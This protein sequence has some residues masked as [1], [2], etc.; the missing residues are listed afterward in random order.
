MRILIGNSVG[1]LLMTL[2]AGTVF[3]SAGLPRQECR[4]E[5]NAVY[6]VYL[7]TYTQGVSRGIYTCEMDTARGTLSAPKLVAEARN[8]S[9]LALHPTL[10]RL[11]AVSELWQTDGPDRGAVSA[12]A[13]DDASGGLRELNQEAVGGA[14]PCH[15]AASPSGRFLVTANYGSGSV[16]VLPLDDEGRLRPRSCVVQHEGSGPNQSRQEGPHAHQ[17]LFSPG[18]EIL[19]V[20]D[21]GIDQILLYRL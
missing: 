19:L 9:F 13:I 2:S 16:S 8:P 6:R 3:L 5:E 11:Y 1:I 14:G 17:T 18:G 7:G 12:F 4:A 10:P 15:L 20:P 21:L